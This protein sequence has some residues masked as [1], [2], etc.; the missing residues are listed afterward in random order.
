MKPEIYFP[1]LGIKI[2][3]LNRVAFEIFGQ[4]I[5]WYGIII[6]SSIILGYFLIDKRLRKQGEKI[7]DYLNL[8]IACLIFSII[9]ARLYYVVFSFDSY[10]DN[11]AKIFDLRNGGIAIYGAVIAILLTTFIYSKI[12]KKD[13]F[14][15]YDLFI[16]YLLLGQAFGRWGNFINKEAFGGYT[17]NLFAMALRKDTVRYIPESLMGTEVFYEGIEY[18][19]VHP[20]FFYESICSFLLFAFLIWY[21]NNKQKFNGELFCIYLLGYSTYRFFIEGLRTDQLKIGFIPISQIVAIV[22]ILISVIIYL[23]LYKKN[24]KVKQTKID[25][26]FNV[27]E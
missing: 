21:R 20:T 2:S 27:S 1:N 7:D 23:K 5:Y 19:K 26:D 15:L 11:I 10:K 9:G 18:I 13:I 17:D 3:N 4:K 16:P 12:K 6:V 24:E 14:K 22:L 8:I 25:K